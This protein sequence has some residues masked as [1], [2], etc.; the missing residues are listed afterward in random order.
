MKTGRT[1]FSI[2]MFGLAK[3]PLACGDLNDFSARGR[4]CKMC[5]GAGTVSGRGPTS[6]LLKDYLEP[7][8]SPVLGLLFIPKFGTSMSALLVGVRVMPTSRR[9]RNR[10]T[11][12]GAPVTSMARMWLR[13]RTGAFTAAWP[14][15]SPAIRAKELST[16]YYDDLKLVPLDAAE[17]K[18]GPAGPKPL[19]IYAD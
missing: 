15:W 5:V 7:R 1:S 14:D 16:A 4:R 11:C 17:P 6:V 12:T 8:H 2:F 9:T 3:A 10:A 19:P 13:S 18:A